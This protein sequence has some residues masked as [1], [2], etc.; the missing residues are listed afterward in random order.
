MSL[1]SPDSIAGTLASMSGP[2]MNPRAL[3]ELLAGV[4]ALT[5]TDLSAFVKAHFGKDQRAIVTLKHTPG[6]KPATKAAAPKGGAR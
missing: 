5:P 6:A 4:D 1:V 3:D 2:S